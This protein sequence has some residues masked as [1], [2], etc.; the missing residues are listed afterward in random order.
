M[1]TGKLIASGL[2]PPNA[3]CFSDVDLQLTVARLKGIVQNARPRM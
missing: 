3:S 2:A 1:K